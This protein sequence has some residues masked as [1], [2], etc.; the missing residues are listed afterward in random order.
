MNGPR[1]PASQGWVKMQQVINDV[2]IHYNLNELTGET[3]DW[4]FK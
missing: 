3:A 2:V 1:W 4:K